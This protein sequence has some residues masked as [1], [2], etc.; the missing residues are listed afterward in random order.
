VDG[1][2]RRMLW[3]LALGDV[4]PREAAFDPWG[5]SVP[6]SQLEALERVA[7]GLPDS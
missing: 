2:V 6:D 7:R 3:L 5:P 4:I 1:Y